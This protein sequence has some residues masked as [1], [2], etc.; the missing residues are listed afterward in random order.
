MNNITDKVVNGMLDLQ[1][2]TEDFSETLGHIVYDDPKVN[3]ENELH[4]KLLESLS[5]DFETLSPILD[6]INAMMSRTIDIV[7][8]KGF[9][10]AIN[11]IKD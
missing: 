4:N 10:D 7:Y 1:I 3:A 6:S 8:K 9:L 5:L 11:I 2:L